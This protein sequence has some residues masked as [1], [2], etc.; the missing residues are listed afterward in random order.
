MFAMNTTH[1]S[2]LVIEKHPLLREALCAAIASENG[3]MEVLGMSDAFATIPLVTMRQPTLVL[4]AM[5]GELLDDVLTITTLRQSLPNTP[6][7]A[8][9]SDEAPGQA[10][11]ALVH[12]T[13]A[14][15]SKLASRDD[16]LAALWRLLPKAIEIDPR[17]TRNPKEASGEDNPLY[18][19]PSQSA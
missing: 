8:L 9:V 7:L 13:Q 19:F 12:G 16:L 15:I 4:F 5:E 10:Q 11:A 1:I 2:V 18:L 6:I 14:T 3:Q 17:Q